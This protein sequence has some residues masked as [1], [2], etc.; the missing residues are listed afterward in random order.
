MTVHIQEQAMMKAALYYGSH[1]IR[2]DQVPEPKPSDGQLI[3]DVEWC[4]E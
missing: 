2:I 3:V 1:D 4:G